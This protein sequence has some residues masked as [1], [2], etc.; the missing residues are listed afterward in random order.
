M[1]TRRKKRPRAPSRQPEGEPEGFPQWE[2]ESSFT[3]EGEIERLGAISRNMSSA[4][5]WTRLVARFVVVGMLVPFA[6]AL[7]LFVV[8]LFR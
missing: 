2:H 7:V 3:F 5:R 8:D 4:P 1:A 6:V